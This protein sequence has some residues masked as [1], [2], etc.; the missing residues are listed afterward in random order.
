[1]K[2]ENTKR[3]LTISAFKIKRYRNSFLGY[4]ILMLIFSLLLI[5]ITFPRQTVFASPGEP[6]FC[7]PTSQSITVQNSKIAIHYPIPGSCTDGRNAP[8]PTIVFAH[9]FSM[10]GITNGVLLN[11]GNGEHLASWGYIVAIPKLP[12]DAENRAGLVQDIIDALETATLD[13]ESFL[14]NLV[15]TDRFATAGHSLG[16]ATALTVAARDPRIKATVGLDPVF[17]MGGPFGSGEMVWDPYLE[18]PNILVPTAILGAPP[19]PCNAEGDSA[20]LY[21]LVGANKKAYYTL[22]GANHWVFADPGSPL[23]YDFCGGST[24]PILT[25]LSQKYMTAWF[26]YYLYNHFSDYYYL[27]GDGALQDVL[28]GL[29]LMEVNIDPGTIYLPILM[30]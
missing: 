17:H 12:D 2:D 27:Y 10:F 21:P 5:N 6:G 24:D 18:G 28:D 25:T 29:I 30:K 1:M 9:G 16:G 8:F 14:Y 23:L 4:T 15:D 20:L 13:P 3:Q 22:I 11:Q 7:T 26:N 19:D